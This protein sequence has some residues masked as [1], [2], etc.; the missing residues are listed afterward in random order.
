MAHKS[1]NH[2]KIAP[3][4]HNRRVFSDSHPSYKDVTRVSRQATK[5]I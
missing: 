1:E 5:E 4:R 2:V 3:G